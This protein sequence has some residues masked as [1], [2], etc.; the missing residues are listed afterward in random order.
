[1]ESKSHSNV[2]ERRTLKFD[3]AAFPLIAC[4][5]IKAGERER[6]HQIR[7]EKKTNIENEERK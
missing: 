1:M 4:K 3:L 5:S 2:D 7:L 6:D